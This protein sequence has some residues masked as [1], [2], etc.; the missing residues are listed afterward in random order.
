MFGEDDINFDL[1]LEMFCFDMNILKEPAV[2]RIFRAWVEDW[3][4]DAR[5]NNDIVAEA[6]LLQKY[7]SLVFH[8]PDTD[9][10][11]CI[12]DQNMEFHHGR[13]NGWFVLGV[14]STNAV[15]DEG[16]LLELACELIG[17]T[18]QKEGIQVM[19]R[20]NPE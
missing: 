18:P 10:G 6:R 13:G 5:K 19:L 1:Q 20:E 9:N 12:Y 16:F 8:D 2:Q 11:F 7:R 4:Q 17:R 3:E 14:C 15:E